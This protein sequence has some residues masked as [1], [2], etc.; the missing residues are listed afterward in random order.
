MTRLSSPHYLVLKPLGEQLEARAADLGESNP[1]PQILDVGCGPK[2]YQ[3]LFSKYRGNYWGVDISKRSKADLL[4]PMECLPVRDRAVDAIVCTQV[5]QS[6]RHPRRALVEMRRVLR[7]TGILLLSTPGTWLRD[8]GTADYWRWTDEGLRLASEEAGYDVLEVLPSGGIIACL[9]YLT[10]NALSGLSH[11][12]PL[13]APIRWLLVP[14]LNLLGEGLDRTL[15]QLSPSS[16]LL[17]VGNYLLV[18]RR[19]LD[20]T[21]KSSG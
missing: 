15:T 20:P 4:G 8:P 11:Q 5:F 13:L 7:P 9:T 19:S 1:M 12:S 10:V 2:P 21:T 3:P 14:L 16:K 6:C 18:A 17:L